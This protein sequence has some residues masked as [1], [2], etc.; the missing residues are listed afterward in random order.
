MPT[1]EQ[2]LKTEFSE[3]FVEKMRN[4]MVQGYYS[5]GPASKNQKHCIKHGDMVESIKMR[6]QKYM[7]TGN[8]EWL[9]DASNLAMIEFMYPKHPD[10][11]YR[12][13][14]S[15]ESPGFACPTIK[16]LERDA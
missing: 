1:P 14:D 8:T 9:V 10:A 15:H 4:A 2:I 13:T 6:L 7:K 12:A 16:E 5:H 3:E 11:H